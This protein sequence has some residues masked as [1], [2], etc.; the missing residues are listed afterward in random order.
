VFE[1]FRISYNEAAFRNFGEMFKDAMDKKDIDEASRCFSEMDGYYK[2]LEKLYDKAR[3]EN[4]NI[5]GVHIIATATLG[6]VRGELNEDKYDSM[7]A[8]AE[9]LLGSLEEGDP[10]LERLCDAI[11]PYYEEMMRLYCMSH[12]GEP[13]KEDFV[14]M[15]TNAFE[16]AY[17]NGHAEG[18]FETKHHFIVWISKVRKMWRRDKEFL[19]ENLKF[20]HSANS[21]GTSGSKPAKKSKALKPSPHK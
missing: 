14:H 7:I 5:K 11:N 15:L 13:G 21:D 17:D 10:K 9:E 20:Y 16:K 2:C 6:M 1:K 8:E 19:D 4:K 12:K 3:I 18:M